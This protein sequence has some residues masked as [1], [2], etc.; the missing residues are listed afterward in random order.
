M[1][2][3][4]R[5]WLGIPQDSRPPTHY[6]LLGI[7]PD[8]NDREVIH[9]A[10][11]R[12]SAYVRNF[13]GGQYAEEATRILNEIAA[14][15]L[16]LLNPARRAEY[17]AAL[18]KAPGLSPTSASRLPPLTQPSRPA[19][20]PGVPAR[21]A[22]SIPPGQRPPGPANRGSALG[23]PAPG[24]GEELFEAF[25]QPAVHEAVRLGQDGRGRLPARLRSISRVKTPA[26]YWLVP[27]SMAAAG[28]ILVT[29]ML[30]VRGRGGAD[31][32]RPD[33]DEGRIVGP[34]ASASAA[35]AG[36]GPAADRE[37]QQPT[38]A[39]GQQLVKPIVTDRSP[40][41]SS[42]PPPG[43]SVDSSGSPAAQSGGN[44]VSIT[45]SG[46]GLPGSAGDGFDGISVGGEAGMDDD[47][48]VRIPLPEPGTPVVFAGGVAPFV[49]VGNQ[50][51]NL[52]TVEA[53]GK[54]GGN[55]L[56]DAMR[57][58]SPDGKHYAVGNQG[59][60]PW[61]EVGSCQT[62]SRVH[63]LPFRRPRIEL[64]FLEFAG[65]GSLV[66]SASALGDQ[67]VQLWDISSGK[68]LKEFRTEQFE[69]KKASLSR[70]GKYLAAA[71]R[72]GVFV[73]DVQ[74]GKVAAR[75]TPAAMRPGRVDIDGLAFSPDGQ[76]LAMLTDQG[77]RIVCFNGRAELVFEHALSI[78]GTDGWFPFYR[79][80][81]IE[82]EPGG[83]GWLLNGRSLF[84]RPRRQV[85]WRIKNMDHQDARARF[86]DE[87][88][89]LVPRGEGDSRELVGLAIPWRRIE[90]EL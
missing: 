38:A 47:A 89:V 54:L 5:K 36:S 73:Y 83:R 48:T 32:A 87:D 27:I 26:Y 16:C 56:P 62:G 67:R 86:L 90:A 78:D 70:D 84:H 46:S 80:P 61:I 15:Q 52:E 41:G 82:W 72:F 30:A 60:I 69:S 79:G 50:V 14:A 77:K 63:L 37:P 3:P 12:Q 10:V 11:V 20:L 7:S 64:K 49:V 55:P 31:S 85:V 18:K 53:V 13:Q 17:D 9:A 43:V 23:H 21:P 74:K 71:T 2:D 42:G 6:Q 59:E 34:G 19:P 29:V 33:L 51:W 8:E 57:A 45:R 25:P 81:A 24:P 76:E 88:H 68:L 66:S 28:L 75:M 1:F 40:S 58:V 39:N 35:A 44:Q 22:V 4:Y 65:T